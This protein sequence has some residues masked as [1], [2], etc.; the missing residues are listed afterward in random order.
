MVDNKR[1]FNN[2]DDDNAVFITDK[3]FEA[4]I[5][6]SPDPE[7]L[8]REERVA[9]KIADD[10]IARAAEA[11]KKYGKPKNPEGWEAAWEKLQKSL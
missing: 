10:Y 11:E 4:I 1:Y 8:R 9:C 6:D 7:G 3:E 5:N 2:E